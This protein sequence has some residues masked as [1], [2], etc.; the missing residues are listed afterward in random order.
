MDDECEDGAPNQITKKTTKTGF[1][2]FQ[3]IIPPPSPERVAGVW[4][5]VVLPVHKSTRPSAE[6][7]PPGAASD[8]CS[9]QC[10][11]KSS[12]NSSWTRA[13]CIRSQ[14]ARQRQHQRAPKS[15][16]LRR[17]GGTG[18][19]RLSPPI[20][21]FQFPLCL[22]A[23]HRDGCILPWSVAIWVSSQWIFLNYVWKKS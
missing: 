21:D 6:K 22:P 15:F 18:A 14:F 13:L 5:V 2:I 8:C 17:F 19:V 1:H 16:L 4:Y 20:I 3:S 11:Q 23:S 9:W 10:R 12:S 7:C